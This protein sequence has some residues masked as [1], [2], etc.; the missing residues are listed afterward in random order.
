VK[1]NLISVVCSAAAYISLAVSTCAQSSFQNLSFESAR[2]FFDPS[3]PV[4]YNPVN[5]T[6]AF[7][8]WTIYGGFTYPGVLYNNEALDSAS[9]SLLS[10]NYEFGLPG[11]ASG[12]FYV[13]LR[14]ASFDLTQIPAI[15]QTAQIPVS[16]ISL[17][18]I[19][20]YP[21]NVTFQGQPIPLVNMGNFGNYYAEYYSIYGG[22]VSAYAGQVGELRFSSGFSYF[23]NIRF[24]TQPIPEPSGLSLFVFSSL[25]LVFSHWRISLSACSQFVKR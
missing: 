24:S 14:G 10:T 21:P 5:A 23:D 15:G 4:G 19:A 9:I 6:N 18:L 16:A 3:V 22:D 20:Y 2:L 7:R 1:T 8:G 17:T 12:A 13:K 25:L 11:F